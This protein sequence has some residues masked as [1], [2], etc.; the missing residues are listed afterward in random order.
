[1]T[2]EEEDLITKNTPLENFLLVRLAQVHRLGEPMGATDL[3]GCDGSSAHHE[4]GDSN[5][6]NFGPS[7][8][9]IMSSRE[10]RKLKSPFAR[11]W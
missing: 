5:G 10:S 11:N 9:L 7:P 6:G 8:K 1:M 3:C 2:K 4:L